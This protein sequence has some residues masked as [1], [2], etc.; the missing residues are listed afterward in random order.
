MTT[1]STSICP[2]QEFGHEL[3]HATLEGIS[4]LTD[5]YDVGITMNR[6]IKL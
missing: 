4:T 1:Q 6:L 5:G 3:T 2:F